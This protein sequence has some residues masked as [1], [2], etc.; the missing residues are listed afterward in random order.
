MP[1][2]VALQ[3]QASPPWAEEESAS[4][5]GRG[6][7]SREAGTQLRAELTLCLPLRLKHRLSQVLLQTGFGEPRFHAALV[8]RLLT[9]TPGFGDGLD[10]GL[11]RRSGTEQLFLRHSFRRMVA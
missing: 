8:K 1:R 6:Q 3:D 7:E 10:P 11:A 9:A 4:E 5:N 2:K